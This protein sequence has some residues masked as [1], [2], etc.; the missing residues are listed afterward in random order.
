MIHKTELK[1]KY[2]TYVD[3]QYKIRTEKVV[4][5]SG[6]YL[7]V[8]TTRRIKNLHKFPKRRIY[9]DQVLGRQHRKK[10]MEKIKWK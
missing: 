4:R 5:V 9:K 1:G 7:T 3:K 8:R 2:V 10:G 6:N